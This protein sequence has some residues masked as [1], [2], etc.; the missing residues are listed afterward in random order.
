MTKKSPKGKAKSIVVKKPLSK[1]DLAEYIQLVNLCNAQHWRAD[2]VAGNTALIYNGQETA[3]TEADIAKLLENSKNNWL[4][5]VLAGCGIPLGQA[6]EVN[7]KTGE[8][9]EVSQ[10]EEEPVEIPKEI[11]KKVEKKVK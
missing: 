10:K 8:I 7:M 6:V 9:R 3:K 2:L 5:N 1:S 11:I 4:S